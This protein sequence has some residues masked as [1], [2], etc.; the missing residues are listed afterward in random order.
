MTMPLI[1]RITA[2]DLAG[3]EMTQHYANKTWFEPQDRVDIEGGG[4]TRLG[5][6]AI[7]NQSE[8]FHYRPR[9]AGELEQYAERIQVVSPSELKEWVG[10]DMVCFVNV[11]K[12]WMSRDLGVRPEV[13]FKLK[14]PAEE[15][16]DPRRLRLKIKAIDT[17]TRPPRVTLEDYKLE[18]L[19][20]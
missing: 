12:G 3:W 13:K 11:E 4:F 16:R 10:K 8:S 18:E 17:S 5:E 6:Q 20:G 14:A 1:I 15:L 7:T 9:L 2:E 19:K